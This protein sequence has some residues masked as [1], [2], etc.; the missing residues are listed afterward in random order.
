VPPLSFFRQASTSVNGLRFNIF[1][2]KP[3]AIPLPPFS[4]TVVLLEESS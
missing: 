1:V 2:A 3:T 4:R